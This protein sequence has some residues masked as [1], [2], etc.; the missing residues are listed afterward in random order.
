MQCFLINFVTK[1]SL[2]I[3]W[4]WASL[5]KCK[6][7]KNVGTECFDIWCPRF[8]HRY[9]LH[10]SI[11]DS[12][13]I[14]VPMSLGLLSQ[15]DCENDS[16]DNDSVLQSECEKWHCLC[17]SQGCNPLFLFDSCDRANDDGFVDFAY[18]FASHDGFWCSMTRSDIAEETSQKISWISVQW[19]DSTSFQLLCSSESCNRIINI[20]DWL[21]LIEY[22]QN[23]YSSICRWYWE[24]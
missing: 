4:D 16:I 15:F 8:W 11:L 13:V 1:I 22:R 20:R 10:R 5:Q 24:R 21:I 2:C 3:V 12:N 17:H 19:C 6:I 9:S 14:W 23:R 18:L 7:S